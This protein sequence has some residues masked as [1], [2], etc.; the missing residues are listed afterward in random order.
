MSHIGMWGQGRNSR[1]NNGQAWIGNGG[2]NT[3]TFYNHARFVVTLVLWT[4]ATSWVNVN[5]PQITWSLAPGQRVTVSLAN[6]V[7]GAWS[8][9]YN[10]RTILVDGQIFNTWGEF[11]T[12]GWATVD[13]TREPN[14]GGNAMNAK[15]ST[16]CL[17]DMNSCSFQC[18]SGNR[19]GAAGSYKLVNCVGPNKANG[20]DPWGQPSGGC[21]GWSNGGHIDAGFY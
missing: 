12:G 5:Q 8:G 21:Q 9:L 17:A 20:I 19:C 13:I 6:G 18:K 10:H 11:T 1:G 2:P 15:V 3:I 16:G 14:M 7:S 4:G